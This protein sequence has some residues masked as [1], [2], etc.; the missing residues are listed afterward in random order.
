M[1]P[2]IPTTNCQLLFT[3]PVPRDRFVYYE[4]SVNV[5]IASNMQPKHQETFLLKLVISGYSQEI[6]M[7]KLCIYFDVL[8]HITHYTVFTLLKKINTCGPI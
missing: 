3:P 2:H 5:K 1:T 7:L 6:F 4:N 8:H